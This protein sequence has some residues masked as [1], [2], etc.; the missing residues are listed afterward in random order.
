[1]DAGIVAIAVSGCRNLT[2]PIPLDRKYRIC[3]TVAP[4]SAEAKVHDNPARPKALEAGK[5]RA[6]DRVDHGRANSALVVVR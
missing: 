3:G 6:A 4:A 5:R 2:R 1:M